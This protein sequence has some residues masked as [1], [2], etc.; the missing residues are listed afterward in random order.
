MSTI[1]EYSVRCAVCSSKSQQRQITSYSQF[2][3]PDLDFR[4]GTMYRGTMEYWIEECPRCGYINTSV[5]KSSVFSIEL[6]S[7]THEIV[8]SCYHWQNR[9]AKRFAKF[10]VMLAKSDLHADAAV[11]FLR[12]AWIFDDQNNGKEA[13]HWRKL[14]IKQIELMML[15]QTTPVS[16]KLT[17]MYADMLRRTGDF[18]MVFN[19][20]EHTMSKTNH[21]NLIKYQKELSLKGDCARHQMDEVVLE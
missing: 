18:Q 2:D 3:G 9:Y 5:G 16:E 11:Q 1:R 4:P 21:L 14:A 6:I 8:E 13:A 17:C 20:N 7:K 19:I 12:V 15:Q 10:G